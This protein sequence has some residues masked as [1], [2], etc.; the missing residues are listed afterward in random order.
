VQHFLIVGGN[1]L[2]QTSWAP[3]SLKAS[4][5]IH[6]ASLPQVGDPLTTRSALQKRTLFTPVLHSLYG[7]SAEQI[8]RVLTAIQE[9][10]LPDSAGVPSRL[11][12]RIPTEPVT[13]K[14]ELHQHQLV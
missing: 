11:Q 13:I 14:G 9:H 5:S 12:V 2:V 3:F 1:I 4:A 6:T 10:V 7:D 8:T